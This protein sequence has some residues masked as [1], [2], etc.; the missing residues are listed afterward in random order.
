L[1]LDSRRLLPK[2]LTGWYYPKV[3]IRLSKSII[4]NLLAKCN[5]FNADYQILKLGGVTEW[6]KVTVL[7][8]VFAFSERGFE[9]HPLRGMGS[10]PML[11][12]I[13]YFFLSPI[14]LRA[15]STSST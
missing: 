3:K 12:S 9:S 11:A 15:V 5:Y 2:A 7:K 1:P 4:S 13:E 10:N 14:F 6:F 8:T